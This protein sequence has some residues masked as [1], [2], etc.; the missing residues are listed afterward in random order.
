[1]E[2]TLPTRT[3]PLCPGWRAMDDPSEWTQEHLVVVV[4]DLTETSPENRHDLREC[5]NS[6]MRSLTHDPAATEPPEVSAMTG[7]VGVGRCDTTEGVRIVLVSGGEDGLDSVEMTWEDLRDLVHDAV[8]SCVL[9][10]QQ[11]EFDED[12]EKI[13]LRWADSALI[14]DLPDAQS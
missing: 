13:G 10:W 14:S 2:H 9:T 11:R 6:W 5:I 8:P 7:G 4:T 1:M 12:A 3:Q